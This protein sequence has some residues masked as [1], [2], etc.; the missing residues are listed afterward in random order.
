[1]ELAGTDF[2]SKN[3]ALKR[4]RAKQKA[5]R[6]A[7]NMGKAISKAKVPSKEIRHGKTKITVNGK[8]SPH[9]KPKTVKPKL[10]SRPAVTPPTGKKATKPVTKPTAKPVTKPTK[11][12]ATRK[13]DIL[14][15]M[16]RG[17][18]LKTKTTEADKKQLSKLLAK[19]KVEPKGAYAKLL[20]AD[21]TKGFAKGGAGHRSSI[22]ATTPKSAKIKLL[23][24]LA[25]KHLGIDQSQ[26]GYSRAGAGDVAIEVG[27]KALDAWL[28]A[29]GGKAAWGTAKQLKHAPGLASKMKPWLTG[30]KPIMSKEFIKTLGGKNLKSFTEF[31]KGKKTW[32]EAFPTKA[33][34]L[35]KREQR[36]RSAKA[37]ETRAQNEADRIAAVKRNKELAAA[38]K[39]ADKAAKKKADSPPKTPAKKTPTKKTPAK[40]TPAKKKVA[41]A[42]TNKATKPINKPYK[43][44][45]KH[46]LKSW[47]APAK[48]KAVKKPV[49]KTPERVTMEV[50]KDMLKEKP[51]KMSQAAKEWLL[52]TKTPIKKA[53]K[54]RR[55]RQKGGQQL[56]KKA[57]K[58]KKK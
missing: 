37:S 20:E 32:K 36:R 12:S 8:P 56:V 46:P 17:K 57:V 45:T 34:S 31:V 41:K 29:S 9:L 19:K 21:K 5:L 4:K 7:K 50:L 30:K 52:G 22:S 40:K 1:M 2:A 26:T 11:T 55:Q 25:P 44:P 51:E 48:K 18:N 54:K 39:K 6:I 14:H 38:K 58:K 24:Y 28:T 23:E 15:G 3:A 33:P 47:K 53:V 13:R 27:K 43:T 16:V 49:G 10:P 35:S 42:P